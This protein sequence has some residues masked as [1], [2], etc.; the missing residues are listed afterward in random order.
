MNETINLFRTADAL[1]FFRDEGGY[2]VLFPNL[3]I[4]V[5]SLN[6]ASEVARENG[7]ESLEVRFPHGGRDRVRL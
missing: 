6:E 5:E 4:D 2:R 3:G 1:V 7:A